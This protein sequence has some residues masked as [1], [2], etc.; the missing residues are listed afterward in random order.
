MDI[1]K[2]HQAHVVGNSLGAPIAV[3][4]HMLKP[5][6]VLSLVLIGKHPPLEV[7]FFF[8]SASRFRR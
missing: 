1:L 2:I 4:M 7:G 8:V 5:D 6:R 3:R